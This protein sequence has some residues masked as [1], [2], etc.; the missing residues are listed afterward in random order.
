[1]CR[2]KIK[3]NLAASEQMIIYLCRNVSYVSQE[4]IGLGIIDK[5]HRIK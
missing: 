2:L 4:V 5:C 3:C 1:M